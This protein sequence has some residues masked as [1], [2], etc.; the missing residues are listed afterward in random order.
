[1]KL[2]ALFGKL[3]QRDPTAMPADRVLRMATIDGARALGLG[4]EIGSLEPGKK[5]DLI[6][7]DTRRPTLQ[8][9]MDDP[10]NLAANLVYAA[11]GDEVDA[12][13]IDGSMILDHGTLR[14]ID[15]PAVLQEIRDSVPR[16]RRPIAF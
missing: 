6:L 4:E 3:A 2:T 10:F 7:I 16:R 15:E 9:V 1:M 12:V 8:P 13:M 5:A 11:R 14:T